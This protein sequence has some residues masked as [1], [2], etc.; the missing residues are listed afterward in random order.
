MDDEEKYNNMYCLFEYGENK[1]TLINSTGW[2]EHKTEQILGVGE[3]EGKKLVVKLYNKEILA[4]NDR[5]LGEGSEEI[6]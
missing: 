6:K 5:F 3:E 2:N 1:I 4:F